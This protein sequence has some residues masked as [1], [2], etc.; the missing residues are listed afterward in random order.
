[1]SNEPNHP[2]DDLKRELAKRGHEGLSGHDPDA[3]EERG[4]LTPG[5]PPGPSQDGWRRVASFSA[6]QTAEFLRGGNIGKPEIHDPEVRAR[7]ERQHRALR[8]ALFEE[9]VPELAKAL[10]RDSPQTGQ[11]L[12]QLSQGA[13]HGDPRASQLLAVVIGELLT[14]GLQYD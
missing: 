3:P 12:L 5:T 8:K 6:E 2:P 13:F 7:M 14:W 11:R 9:V 10:E 4:I 1:M